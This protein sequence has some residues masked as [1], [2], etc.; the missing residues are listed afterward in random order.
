MDHSV[1]CTVESY[2][3]VKTSIL[4]VTKTIA[5]DTK[6]YKN[7]DEGIRKNT[8]GPRGTP[9]QPQRIYNPIMY[10]NGVLGKVYL[11]ALGNTKR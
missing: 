1:I 3:L 10:G 9:I 8:F 2:L 5:T 7:L 4:D 11:L 6:Y